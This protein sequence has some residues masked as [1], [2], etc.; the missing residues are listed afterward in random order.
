M[1]SFREFIDPSN[2]ITEETIELFAALSEAHPI[3]KNNATIQRIINNRSAVISL[4]EIAR[5][6][7][8]ILARSI[9]LARQA[10]SATL[11]KRTLILCEQNLLNTIASTISAAVSAQSQQSIDRLSRITKALR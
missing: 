9:T 4:H 3:L 5:V 6:N 2:S 8:E 7:K 10:A 11:D 1:K